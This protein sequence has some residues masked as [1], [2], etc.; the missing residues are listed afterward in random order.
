MVAVGK[1]GIQRAGAYAA[2]ILFALT[3]FSIPVSAQNPQCDYD[4]YARPDPVL[5]CFQL[6]VTPAGVV[7]GTSNLVHVTMT[8]NEPIRQSEGVTFQL[9]GYDVMFPSDPNP[10]IVLAAGQT[11]V[12]IDA[13]A[14]GPVGQSDQGYVVAVRQTFSKSF[15]M[16]SNFFSDLPTTI[17]IQ[18]DKTTVGSG[19]SVTLIISFSDA[20]RSPQT[21]RAQDV[22]GGQPADVVVPPGGTGTYTYQAP[23]TI[24]FPGSVRLTVSTLAPPFSRGY[25][26]ASVLITLMPQHTSYTADFSVQP[27]P[28]AGGTALSVG[29]TLSSAAQ[30]GMA[31]N[32][33]S[34][35]SNG[36]FLYARPNTNPALFPAG[37][38]TQTYSL[39]AHV[40]SQS[41]TITCSP[42]YSWPESPQQQLTLGSYQVQINPPQLLLSAPAST[43]GGTV[44]V[45]ISLTPANQYDVPFEL[46]S[47]VPTVIPNTSRT[48]TIGGNAA[49]D[50]PVTPQS[51]VESVT[52]TAR[53]AT[54]TGYLQITSTVLM[55]D[56]ELLIG[57][58]SGPS[59]PTTASKAVSGTIT[60]RI[61]LGHVFFV[62]LVRKN[63]NGVRT[64]IDSTFTINSATIAPALTEDTLFRNIVAVVFGPAAP[65]TVKYFQTMHLGTMEILIYP[66]DG[67][68]PVR[69]ALSVIVPQT[70]GTT[71]NTYDPQIIDLAHRFGIPPQFLKAQVQQ[72]SD[73]DPS[74]FRYELLS[75]D[76]QEVSGGEQLRTKEPYSLFRLATSDGL[77]DG[78]QL[79]SADKSPRNVF[80]IL[81]GGTIPRNIVDTDQLVSAKEIYT[82]NESWV[83]WRKF[84][85]QTRLDELDKNPNALDFTAQ[86]TLASSYG[87]MQVL[88]RLAVE[89]LKWTGAN[90]AKNPSNLSDTPANLGTGGG[91]LRLGATYLRICFTRANK[92]VPSWSLENP[93]SADSVQNL[94]FKA[95]NWYNHNGTKG[96]YG[97]E[98]V[99][100]ISSFLP[101]TT[102]PIF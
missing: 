31:V 71:L 87:L 22:F 14:V 48:L 45:Q 61:P 58:G 38:R 84:L 79:R 34:P 64:P 21:L 88:Y 67:S 74:T 101:R 98:T 19:G 43:S 68:D 69:V 92:R 16:Y 82:Y 70:L 93:N 7:G 32:V 46:V 91:S 53:I 86:T 59:D 18:P 1:F 6:L 65:T 13:Y 40:Y 52:L 9:D 99:A 49:F 12:T 17:V 66:A 41:S 50:L 10:F 57:T 102:T 30:S 11:S 55:D 5:Y 78:Q 39:I 83:H 20:M 37:L 24:L 35:C 23:S 26:T 8:V 89:D 72:E 62:E 77:A 81:R 80:K 4:D 2:L 75:K 60:A 3:L 54:P 25:I 73:F 95:F 96:T 42:Y 100:R 44:H 76:W 33:G 28:V 29:V 36:D 94:F 27:Q 15:F 56:R 97:T 63:A 90:G 47:S 51:G 85:R